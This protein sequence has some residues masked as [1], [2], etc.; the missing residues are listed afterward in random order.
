VEDLFFLTVAVLLIAWVIDQARRYRR[1]PPARR[2]QQKWLLA[3]AAIC[4]LSLVLSIS[5]DSSPH[6]SSVSQWIGTIAPAGLVALPL[7]I[8]IGITKYRLYEIDR[9]T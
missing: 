9:L 7:G 8:G 4:V 6:P 1:L 5:T 2:V 3:R